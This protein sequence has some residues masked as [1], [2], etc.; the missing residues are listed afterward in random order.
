M[1][2]TGRLDDGKQATVVLGDDARRNW[3]AELL[4]SQSRNVQVDEGTRA[5]DVT[6]RDRKNKRNEFQV[7]VDR[8]H[9]SLGAAFKFLCEH[10]DQVPTVGLV[11]LEENS[12]GSSVRKMPNAAISN[13]RCIEHRGV[14]TKFSYTVTGGKFTS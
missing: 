3:I 7:I 12:N 10:A 1:T 4:P 5:D 9:D 8:T 13:I 2:I 11:T 14:S 6:V